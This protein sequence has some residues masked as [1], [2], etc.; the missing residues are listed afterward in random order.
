MGLKKIMVYEILPGGRGI[1]GGGGVGAGSG[2]PYLAS[3]L[4]VVVMSSGLQKQWK[5]EKNLKKDQ[6]DI[7]K[8][9]RGRRKKLIFHEVQGQVDTIKTN[10]SPVS[11]IS[12][13]SVYYIP[14]NGI[15][16]FKQ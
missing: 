1:G 3:G 8:N 9:G 13:T 11:S 6:I 2:K 5:G 12:L 14:T 15:F 16:N 4:N 7:R 10:I